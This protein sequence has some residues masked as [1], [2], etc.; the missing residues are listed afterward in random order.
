[1]ERQQN[2]RSSSQLNPPW[3]RIR[4]VMMNLARLHY[5]PCLTPSMIDDHLCPPRHGLLGTVCAHI[6]MVTVFPGPFLPF[7]L[8]CTLK[9]VCLLTFDGP[10]PTP[11]AIYLAPTR[12]AICQSQWIPGLIALFL[13]RILRADLLLT[14]RPDCT[15]IGRECCPSP[16][17]RISS[18]FPTRRTRI[19]H[20]S[21]RRP[22]DMAGWP[23]V[24]T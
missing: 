22:Q 13:L 11:V 18:R 24:F 3:R 6:V 17:G 21:R 1:M 14:R 4:T 16:W 20:P 7:P 10:T 2:V 23:L 12:L 8:V 5:L 9:C 19:L 15:G